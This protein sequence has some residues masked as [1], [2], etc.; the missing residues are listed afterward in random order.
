MKMCQPGDEVVLLDG[1]PGVRKADR[2]SGEH[3]R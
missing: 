2:R 1:R 3:G